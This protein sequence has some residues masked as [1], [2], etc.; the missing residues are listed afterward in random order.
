MEPADRKGITIQRL[1]PDTKEQK[2]GSTLG[3][4]WSCMVAVSLMIMSCNHTEHLINCWWHGDDATL[5]FVRQ[6]I[7]GLQACALRVT[8]SNLQ[9]TS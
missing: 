2:S 6:S 1:S 4:R 7:Q 3:C 8:C 5:R 9:E